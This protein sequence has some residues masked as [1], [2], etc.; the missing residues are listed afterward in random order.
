MLLNGLTTHIHI[1]TIH[2]DVKQFRLCYLCVSGSKEYGHEVFPTIIVFNPVYKET[3]R[4]HFKPVLPT[5]GVCTAC[6]KFDG[7]Q[8]LRICLE[9]NVKRAEYVFTPCIHRQDEGMT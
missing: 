1:V 7:C 9:I 4:P 3:R 2:A 6:R 8:C 5:A